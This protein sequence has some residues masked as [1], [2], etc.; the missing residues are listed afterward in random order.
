LNV[1]MPVMGHNLLS[2]IEI[3]ENGIRAFTD[4]CVK[5]IQADRERCR[6]YA[7]MSMS[8]VTALNPIIGYAKAAEIVKE[9]L[10]SG[11]TIVETIR[12]KNVLSP[13]KLD[14]VLNLKALTEPGVHK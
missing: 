9:A 4:G 10:A 8:L 7:E 13:E 3:L 6:R 12:L 11:R 5:G 1:M 14:E 2:S